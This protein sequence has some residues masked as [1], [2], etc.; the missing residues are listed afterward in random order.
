VSA[1]RNLADRYADFRAARK[2]LPS[3]PARAS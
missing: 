3:H 2:S 1:T